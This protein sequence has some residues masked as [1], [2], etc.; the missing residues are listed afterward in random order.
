MQSSDLLCIRSSAP[1]LPGPYLQENL[2]PYK[3][4]DQIGGAKPRFILVL[5]GNI[6]GHRFFNDTRQLSSGKFGVR[7]CRQGRTVL[8][9]CEM[10]KQPDDAVPRIIA[11]RIPGHYRYHLVEHPATTMAEL[12]YRVYCD[13]FALF[14]DVV[15][16]HIEGFGGLERVLSFICTWI[17]RQ[18]LQNLALRTHF[19]LVTSKYTIKDIQ[20]ELLAAM[21]AEQRK[22]RLSALESVASLKR[23]ITIFTE[24]SVICE[25]SAG[26][27][28]V[29]K[30][31]NGT[32]HRKAEGLQ[33][34]GANAKVLLRAAIAHY[35]SKPTESF[36]VV[37]ASR[38]AFPVPKELGFHIEEFLSACPGQ[39]ENYYHII[40]SAL[41]MNASHPGFHCEF[42]G[43]FV[44]ID[45]G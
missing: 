4:L 35:T 30:L 9:R 34:T 40:A 28:L 21:V 26:S 10:H 25:Q 7:L 17:Q 18:Q 41:V 24:L 16:I 8:V 39:P 1:G 11:G 38:S 44:H 2:A 45:V 32:G 5:Q 43:T 12:S 33:F 31:C 29:K 22:T 13:V 3:I 23:T 19:V 42:M 6:E 27:D 36:S 37:E 15:L 14:T 20:F